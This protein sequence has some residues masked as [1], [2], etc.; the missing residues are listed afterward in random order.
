MF[1][2]Y[3][4][5]NGKCVK[6]LE[7][8]YVNFPKQLRIIVICCMC[9]G[10]PCFQRQKSVWL[11]YLQYLF[12]L[13]HSSTT[14]RRTYFTVYL[15]ASRFACLNAP[16]V[17]EN[18]RSAYDTRSSGMLNGDIHASFLQWYHNQLSVSTALVHW[19]FNSRILFL[20]TNPVPLFPLFCCFK[21]VMQLQLPWQSFDCHMIGRR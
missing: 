17:L 18:F 16:F 4:C 11:Q 15:F 9:N 7:N 6:L 2:D 8:L 5:L 13:I 10:H 12:A 14:A 1:L 19:T 21:G 20:R 3:V